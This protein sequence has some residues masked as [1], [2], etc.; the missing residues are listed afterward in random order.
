MNTSRSVSRREKYPAPSPET[1]SKRVK[2]LN[3]RG[4]GLFMHR[5]ND[6]DLALMS[7]QSLQRHPA[8]VSPDFSRVIV[9]ACQQ[10]LTICRYGNTKHWLRVCSW[11]HT[12]GYADGVTHTCVCRWSHTHTRVQRWSHTQWYADEAPHT[13]TGVCRWSHTQVHRCNQSKL[14]LEAYSWQ[15]VLVGGYSV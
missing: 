4:R 1:Q 9:R 3:V 15:Q 2:R 12:H 5:R 8:R 10:E 7:C 6:S 14:T 11:S 13:H